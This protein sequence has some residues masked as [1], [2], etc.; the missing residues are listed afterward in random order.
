MTSK[1]LRTFIT[2]TVLAF[3]APVWAS[4]AYPNRPIRMLVPF[5]AGGAID[6]MA[7]PTARKLHELL[8]QAVVVDNRTGAGGS[9]AAEATAKSPNDGY[10]VFF[11]STSPLAI[12][13]AYFDRVGYDTLRDFTPISLAVKQP[14]LIVAHPSLPVKNLRDVVALAKRQPGRLSYGSAGPGTSNH[15]V[16]ELLAD[17]A[18]VDIVHVPYKGGA[19]ALTALL[20]GEIELQVSQPNTMM[21]YVK[22]GR[23]RAIATTGAA[24]LRQLPEVGTLVEAGYKDLDIIGWYCIVGPANLPAPIV[25]KLNGAIRQAIASAELRAMLI[26]AGTEPGTSTPAELHALIKSELV[27]W[28]RAAKVAKAREQR[29]S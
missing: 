3:A 25:D 5:A 26:E 13:P 14:L 28:T 20:S 10:T 16:G 24:R 8:G 27:R 15:L 7:R 11:G 4:D 2:S 21:P 17:A 18:G 29:R 23:V 9:I 22:S 19:P 1:L 12:N 6:L